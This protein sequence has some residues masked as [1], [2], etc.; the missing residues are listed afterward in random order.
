[1]LDKAHPDENQG[2]NSPRR[3]SPGQSP[4]PIP[5]VGGSTV[6]GGAS[7]PGYGGVPR[8]PGLSYGWGSRFA[9]SGAGGLFLVSTFTKVETTA[10][11]VQV[12]LD[13]TARFCEQGPSQEELERTQSYLC[14][15]YPL[16]LETHDQLAEKLADLE[17]YGL[18]E[19]EVS[20]F[21]DRVR[22]VTPDACRAIA[23]RYFPLER[24]VVVAVGPA[25]AIART[26]ER[27]GPVKV[28]PARKMV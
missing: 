11:I 1:M 5:G 21:R 24:R 25:R 6:L 13:E 10:E 20:R 12:A 23:R 8:E 2:P 28:I 22:A 26:L 14:G 19:A 17:L 15:L 7:P 27:F 18:D 4:G 9:S 3:A 16:S